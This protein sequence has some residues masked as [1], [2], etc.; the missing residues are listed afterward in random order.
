MVDELREQRD[1]YV[2]ASA[3]FCDERDELR[4]KLAEA[5]QFERDERSI[6]ETTDIEIVELAQQ[7]EAA[8]AKLAATV[9]WHQEATEWKLTAKTLEAKL[10]EAEAG[11][12]ELA[13]E[14]DR[15]RK[16]AQVAEAR[17]KELEEQVDVVK[18]GV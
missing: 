11:A 7:L 1:A 5:E 12:E 18:E 4:A 17:L 16:R 2:S 13:N 6:R 15:E 14:F 10:A 9:G 3:R 8:E